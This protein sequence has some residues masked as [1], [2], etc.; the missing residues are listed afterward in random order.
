[1]ATRA[2]K[3]DDLVEHVEL[4]AEP[5]VH[6]GLGCF[7]AIEKGRYGTLTLSLT[8][9][10]CFAGSTGTTIS[11]GVSTSSANGAGVLSRSTS[12]TGTVLLET[13]STF[14]ET[15]IRV[16]VIRAYS[17]LTIRTSSSESRMVV[18]RDQTPLRFLALEVCTQVGPSSCFNMVGGKGKIDG[19][20]G[21][22]MWL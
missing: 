9:F 2:V 12:I 11:I 15:A 8:L 18:V 20:I 19:L 13:P 7:L 16:F 21:C 5:G 14:P 4:Y 17:L 3:T 6:L 1:M 22:E 10:D